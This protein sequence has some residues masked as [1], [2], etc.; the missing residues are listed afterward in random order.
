MDSEASSL[1]YL[2]TFDPHV[3]VEFISDEGYLHEKQLL[4]TLHQI[5]DVQEITPFISGKVVA[6]KRNEV[7]IVNLKG[8]E[9]ESGDSVYQIK[10]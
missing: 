7:Q 4:Q 1:H 8:I 9:Q 5:K 3:R 2:V 6:Q 10:I